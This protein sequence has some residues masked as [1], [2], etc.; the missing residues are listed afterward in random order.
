MRV[1]AGLAGA[2]EAL[3]ARHFRRRPSMRIAI[4]LCAGA[5]LTFAAAEATDNARPQPQARTRTVAEKD[6]A[7]FDELVEEAARRARPRLAQVAQTIDQAQNLAVSAKDIEKG[8]T[9]RA[10]YRGWFLFLYEAPDGRP[11]VWFYGVAVRKGT[12]DSCR[13]GTW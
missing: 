12:K 10:E 3:V 6:R 5:L 9:W 7:A 11:F 13:I 4:G 1:R 2:A 8:M